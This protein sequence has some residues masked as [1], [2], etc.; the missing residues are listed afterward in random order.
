MCIFT[1]NSAKLTTFWTVLKEA[2]WGHV[3][4]GDGSSRPGFKGSTERFKS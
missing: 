3:H 1:H 4:A 2:M